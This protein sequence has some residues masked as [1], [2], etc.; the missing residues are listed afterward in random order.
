MG[1]GVTFGGALPHGLAY[2]SV[3]VREREIERDTHTERIYESE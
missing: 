3:Y 2:I 1:S